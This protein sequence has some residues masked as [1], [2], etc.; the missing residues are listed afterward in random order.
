MS[1]GR[2]ETAQAW[3][4]AL[5]SRIRAEAS[6]RGRPIQALA[7]E[8]AYQRFLA[9]VFTGG[10]GG[11]V[12]K[13]GVGLLMRTPVARHSHDVDLVHLHNLDEALAD[14]RR[15]AAIDLGDAIA[16]EI[17][18]AQNLT[19]GI[20][21]TVPIHARIG[22]KTFQR[23]TIDVVT[24]RAIR[25]PVEHSVPSPVV[26]LDEVPALPPFVLYP[27]SAQVADKVCAAFEQH[28][29]GNLPSTRVRDL[30]DL[31]IIACTHRMDAGELADAI[32]AEAARR[33]LVLPARFVLPSEYWRVGYADAVSSAEI[34]AE[35][36]DVDRAVALVGAYLDPILQR[37]LGVNQ[38]DPALRMWSQAQSGEHHQEARPEEGST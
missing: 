16:F 32:S 5:N 17:G 19:T 2:Y 13:G 38:W 37:H 36:G 33:S 23:F 7:R 26:D 29:S 22:A 21:A 28:G 8:L 35:F 27:L 34:R 12:L 25:G 20:G 18:A 4:R 9:R 3:R 31:V 1:I 24:G 30:V 15:I 10:D 14:L 6:R 11:W